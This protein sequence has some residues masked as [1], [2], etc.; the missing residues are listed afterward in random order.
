MLESIMKMYFL[1][2]LLLVV[3]VLSAD[4]NGE[5]HQSQLFL[6]DKIE[7]VIFGKEDIEVVTKSDIERPSLGGGFR[8]KEDIIFEREVLLDAKEHKISS[9]EESVDA[10]IAQVQRE[11]NLSQK[12]LEDIF[13][14]SGYTLEEGRQQLQVMQTVNTMLDVKIRSNLIVPRK[15]VENYYNE[16]PELIE[17]TY[18]LERVVVPFSKKLSKERQLSGLIKIIESGNGME[19]APWSE[20]FTLNHSEI[21]AQKQFIY[22]LEPGQISLPQEIEN[23]FELFKLVEKTAEYRKSLDES[24]R[25]IVDILRRPKYEELMDNYRTMLME[26]M[27]IVYF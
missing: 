21:A 15:D 6:I 22:T 18:T 14:A 3:P 25:D 11:N 2:F 13:T 1:V 7:A 12:D 16:H 17:A 27:S 24:Y 19:K 8:S 10:Y 4:T 23:G 26:H 5:E 20:S 9:D